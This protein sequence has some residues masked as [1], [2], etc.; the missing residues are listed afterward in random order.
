MSP[1]PP[2]LLRPELNPDVI[3]MMATAG[4]VDHGKTKLVRLL[5]G[6]NTDRLKEEQERGLTIE[7]GFA[8]CWIG[9]NLCVGVVDVPGHEKFVRTMVAG[10]SGIDLALLVIAADD[11]IMP[12]TIEHVEIM[13]MMG[14]RHGM[15]ALT[16]IDLVDKVLVEQRSA[17]IRSFLKGTLFEGA[18]V[19]P[20]SSETFEGFEPFYEHLVERVK[21]SVSTRGRGIFRMPVAQYFSRPGFG[22]V[23][24]GIPVD[25]S[26]SIGAQV[27]LTPGGGTGRIRGIQRF[28]RDAGEGGCG[29]CLALN[30]PELPKLQLARGQV[31]CL[32]GYLHPVRQ[33]QVRLTAVSR[34]E[35]PLQNAELIKFHTG[36]SETGGKLYLL[37]E[38]VLPGSRQSFAT[39]LLDSPIAAAAYD[40]FILRR[41]SPATTVAGGTIMEVSE[42]TRR[43]PRKEQAHDLMAQQAFL[44][45]NVPS[46]EQW[47]A[48]R[49]EYFLLHD[50]PMGASPQE[51]SA[52]T[53]LPI[54]TIRRIMPRLNRDSLV[55]ALEAEY[56]IHAH[57]YRSFYDAARER[58][59]QAS[60][61]KQ[62]MSLRRE[63][64]RQ[65]LNYPAPLWD[66]L[67][68]ELE[69]A[70]LIRPQGHK[71]VLPAA[72]E[73][74]DQAE[75]PLI[76]RLLD[77]YA[78][79]G[80][81]SP[82]PDELPG[83]LSES[84]EKIHRVLEHLFDQGKLV[85]VSKNVVL[86]A[87]SFHRAQARVVAIIQ[88]KGVLNS[89]DFK[90]EIDSSRKYA[91][92]ILDWLDARRVTL[93][94]GNDRKLAPDYQIHLL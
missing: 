74:M 56:F 40:R 23:V 82:R 6:C 4:H 28:L 70:E 1:R 49:V 27:E 45:K 88:E 17:E 21:A 50:R 35:R 26:I 52:G 5:T 62:T 19:C 34:L 54:D 32:P 61:S 36:T 24:T 63:E 14:V 33:V 2:G 31:V 44:E 7:L 80:F 75:G 30:I 94:I 13:S 41:L 11:G 10:V 78:Q 91:L 42:E 25:G 67:L 73:M 57:N 53:L 18:P 38:K 83:M 79:T 84:E 89:A 46:S 60:N 81:K 93:R 72:A 16:K 12:Q 87:Q 47:D 55:I 15:V 92:A 37:E 39:I 85:S 29:Q 71:V 69:Q 77:I 20:I 43:L 58:I 22:T 64:L 90:Y 59:L 8:P 68:L 48:G 9:G 51:I 86:S 76:R 65:E 3:M 66:R